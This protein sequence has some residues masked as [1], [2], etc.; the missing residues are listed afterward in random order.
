MI[1]IQ[2]DVRMVASSEDVTASAGADNPLKVVL[3]LN[4]LRSYIFDLQKDFFAACAGS[5]AIVYHPALTIG[6]FA[7]RQMNIPAILASPFPMT[8]TS[9]YPA[10][11]FY[12][13]PRL[14]PGWNRLTH[15]L[16]EQ[17]LWQTG[18]VLL[19]EFWKK[20]FGHVPEHFG[21]PYS[22]QVTRSMPT[23]ISCS[24]YVFPRPADW[25]QEVHL[26]GYWFLGEE[27]GWQPPAELVDFL[28]RGKPPVYVG[29]GSIGN[30]QQAEQTTRLVVAALQRSGQRGLLATG[31]DGMSKAVA[32]PADM[33][34]LESAPH[35]WLF[36]RMSAAVHHGGAATTAAGLRAGVPAIIVP[37]SND[38]FA[39]DRRVWELG[40]GVKPIPRKKLTVEALSEAIN[41][42]LFEQI[43]GAA[44]EMGQKIQA[45]D[46]AGTAARVILDCFG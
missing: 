44:R 24:Q 14:G 42:A 1:P 16:F 7:A 13:S 27:P 28:D 2:G 43:R 38:Q 35:S 46:G 9:E 41:M 30:R 29:F 37:H 32:L 34:I 45:E 12:N 20:Q 6:Y 31:W 15:R 11:I 19:K 40:V 39:W 26:T 21:S 10:L 5:D 25:P 8:P 23:I 33:H 3:G 22:R 4:K 36:P 18:S 17:I